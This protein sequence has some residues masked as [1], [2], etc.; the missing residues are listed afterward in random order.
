MES[1]HKYLAYVGIDFG[2]AGITFSYSIERDR[3]KTD[4][5]EV[6]K[7]KG[8]GTANKTSTEII[9]DSNCEK[10]IAF[11]KGECSTLIQKGIG[12]NLHFSD[13]KM[14][15][16]K[17][18]EKIPDNESKGEY[19]L[20][21]II[22]KFLEKMRDEA[23]G[24]LKSKD[25]YIEKLK[26][27]E[28]IDKV[29]WILTVPAIWSDKSK[30]CMLEAAKM[31]KLIKKGD[32]PSN[33][34]ALEPE[35][36]ACYF[37]KSGNAQNSVL[38][39]PYIICDLGG[40]TADITTHVRKLDKNGNHIISEIYP[41][42]GGDYGS[43][44]INKYILDTLILG[45][46]ISKE[47]R[48]QIEDILKNKG[49]ESEQ[50]K[51][52]FRL[53]EDDVE[54]FK[55]TFDLAKIYD[56][57][58]MNLEALKDGYETPPDLQELVDNFNNNIK[59][60]S[61]KIKIKN[62]KN[63]KKQKWILEF[64]YVIIN[65]LFKELI[66]DKTIV[67]FKQI[68]EYLNRKK[69][70]EIKKINEKDSDKKNV[71]NMKND[72]KTI[73]LAGGMSAN[74][75]IVELYRKAIPNIDIISMP[76]PEIAIVKGAI[77]FAKNPFAISQRIA[78]YSIGIQCVDLWKERFNSI[79]GANKIWN[80]KD[81]VDSC[82][83]RFSVFY[84]KFHSINVSEKGKQRDYDMFTESCEMTFYKS[85]FDG[86]VYVVGQIENGKCITEE[87]GKLQFKVDDFDENDPHIVVEIKMGGTFITAEVEY[88]KT[89]KKKT[90]TFK[91]E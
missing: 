9:L 1:N 71:E 91:F 56:T 52:D 84:K 39:N 86:P 26:D 59:K 50:L 20:I 49:E 18:K 37:A 63:K 69:E 23:I 6:K 5:I 3:E 66:V 81:K 10:I 62:T 12:D 77:Y 57:Y 88:L 80:P 75:S 72:I 42:T 25:T 13:I 47:A 27:S 46:L 53:I 68:M 11:G 36:A 29:K 67:H 58:S 31:A 34:F 4:F 33:F 60:E 65:D 43:R 73:I 15:L 16:Y 14:Y 61:W 40:G 78:R 76:E 28:I 45:K 55:T 21:K 44:A 8:E 83:N 24:E 32:D 85:D 54:T 74:K 87:F 30:T 2:T 64:P 22:S 7:W 48:K 35:A 38:E 17:D 19:P 70:K 79:K 51:Y 90:C 89:K 82:Q 41:P